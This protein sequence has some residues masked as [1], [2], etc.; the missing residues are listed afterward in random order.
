MIKERVRVDRIDCR[1]AI[2][3]APAGETPW[4]IQCKEHDDPG[5]S[6]AVYNDHLHCFGAGCGFHIRRRLDTLGYLLGVWD[7]RGTMDQD[8]VNQVMK[9]ADKYTSEAVDAYR[10][11]VREEAKREPLPLG[12]ARAYN[13]MLHG[14]RAHRKE[15]LHARGF[16]DE[17]IERFMLGYDGPGCRFSIPFLNAE[18]ELLTVRFRRDD[19]YGTEDYTGRIKNKYS[20]MTGRNSSGAYLY[21]EWEVANQAEDYVVVTEAELCAAKLRQESI[22]G[23]ATFNGAGAMRFIPELLR[24]Y[25]WITTIIIL[26][27]MDE[28]G[29]AGA[30]RL[31]DEAVNLG[32]KVGRVKWN[33]KMGKDPTEMYQNGYGE[34]LEQEIQ[35]CR[36][37]IN[38]S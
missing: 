35:E 36:R 2:T 15:Y 14:L 10:E 11:R 29:T 30:R 19:F 3:D 4:F 24:P 13:K 20:G 28:A 25:P 7:G 17:S 33:E 12:L 32:Y 37:V 6:C 1:Y 5:A 38:L 27:D 31:W 22:P 16:T 34:F 21:P 18:R 26:S 9:V 8:Q 23:V